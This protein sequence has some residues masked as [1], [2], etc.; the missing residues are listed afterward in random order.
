VVLSG[1]DRLRGVGEDDCCHDGENLPE[2][3]KGALGNGEIQ[4]AVERRIVAGE[5]D[6]PAIDIDVGVAA[7]GVGDGGVV[8]RREVSHAGF[9]LWV[10]RVGV[11][12]GDGVGSE[13]AHKYFPL[14][15]PASNSLRST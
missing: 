5:D 12:S 4:I 1:R 2:V 3:C 10:T 8:G 7:N 6:C 14:P 9:L 13:G 11:G 15:V